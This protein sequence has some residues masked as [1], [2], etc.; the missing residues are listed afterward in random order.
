MEIK[1]LDPKIVG[2]AVAGDTRLAIPTT[3]FVK[4]SNLMKTSS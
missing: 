1:M 2:R 3:N 4:P